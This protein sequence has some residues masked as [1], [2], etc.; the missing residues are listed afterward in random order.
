M[1]AAEEVA[2][3]WPQAVR[4][5]RIQRGERQRCGEHSGIVHGL[6]NELVGYVQCKGCGSALTYDS[7]T[8]KIKTCKGML[9]D[10]IRQ[11]PRHRTFK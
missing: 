8:Q 7:K 1:D 5:C 11:R 6:I 9:M 4:V 2:G 3:G 10:A